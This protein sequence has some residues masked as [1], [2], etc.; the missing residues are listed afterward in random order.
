MFIKH[1]TLLIRIDYSMTDFSFVDFILFL[2]SFMDNLRANLK[3][4]N[5]KKNN[6]NKFI[7][8]QYHLTV[9]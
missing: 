9:R 3:F 7:L 5:N 6:K 4:I 8:A 1:P 2:I